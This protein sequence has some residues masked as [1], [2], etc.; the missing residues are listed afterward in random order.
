MYWEFW[1]NRCKLPYIEWINKVLLYR[2]FLV[3][4]LVKNLP[5]RWEAWVRTL[6]WEDP[7]KVSISIYLYVHTHIYIYLAI[8]HACRI[9]VSQPGIEPGPVAVETWSPN[10]WTAREFPIFNFFYFR[11]TSYTL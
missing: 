3:A 6:G 8:P 2:T 11:S 9:L 4:Q 10:Y 1:I 7:L 5:A